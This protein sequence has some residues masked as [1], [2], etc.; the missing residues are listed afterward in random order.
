[1]STHD[2]LQ[3]D[4]KAEE[5]RQQRIAT[6]LRCATCNQ[7]LYWLHGYFGCLVWSHGRLWS[8]ALLVQ[9][10][11]D[12]MNTVGA[13]RHKKLVTPAGKEAKGQHQEALGYVSRKRRAYRIT[14]SGVSGNAATARAG[15]NANAETTA[16]IGHG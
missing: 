5:A 9:A 4:Q 12:A 16:A 10:V 14:G 8:K 6:A 13:G 11:V 3:A 15:S 7:P 2:D 1:M